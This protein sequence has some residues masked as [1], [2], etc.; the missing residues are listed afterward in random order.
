MQKILTPAL[1]KHPQLTTIARCLWHMQAPTHKSLPTGIVTGFVR[2]YSEE[3][4]NVV[5][6]L[7]CPSIT[8][9]K[10]L[11]A[12]STRSSSQWF[13]QP[14]RCNNNNS[15]VISISSTCFGRQFRPSSGALDCVYSLWHNTPAMLPV[16]SNAGA[17]YHSIYV[18]IY[19]MYMY[20]LYLW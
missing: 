11:S 1:I 4:F 16:G 9:S 6:E 13:K 10:H 8:S 17:L 5:C 18:C 14:T 7:L 15:L 19:V 20:I 2:L 3:T 12:S